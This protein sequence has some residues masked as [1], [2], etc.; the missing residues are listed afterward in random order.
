MTLDYVHDF[1]KVYKGKRKYAYIPILAGHSFIEKNHEFID[2]HVSKFLKNLEEEGFLKNTIV[3][4]Y[5]DH[6]DHLNGLLRDTP[7]GRIERTHPMHFTILPEGADKKFG[8]NLE[9]N[10]NK[11]YSHYDIFETSRQYTQ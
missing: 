10:R 9:A 8:E 7:S 4:F 3:Q 1:F 6:G 5:S 11:L 2:E